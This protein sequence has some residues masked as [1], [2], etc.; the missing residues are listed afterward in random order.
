MA[1]G[2]VIG[3][4]NGASRSGGLHGPET[5]SGSWMQQGPA[6]MKRVGLG[7]R[8]ACSV[9]VHQHWVAASAP[10]T[11]QRYETIVPPWKFVQ[12]FGRFCPRPTPR[13][14]VPALTRPGPS[15]LF[16]SKIQVELH[17]SVA[18]AP[19]CRRIGSDRV[20]LAI[21]LS[22]YAFGRDALLDQEGPDGLRPSFGQL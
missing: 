3:A 21:A 15:P 22:L 18:L 19:L 11:K 13:G 2:W 16:G 14:P 17:P 4:W 7:E 5:S 12:A 1:G 9:A 8:G 6:Q 20:R 10:Q